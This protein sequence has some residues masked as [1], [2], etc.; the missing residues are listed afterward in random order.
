MDKYIIFL[1]SA[2]HVVH[3]PLAGE[4]VRLLTCFAHVTVV[5]SLISGVEKAL[6]IFGPR[7]ET[8][9]AP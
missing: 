3:D 5:R 7:H 8:M 6:A 4:L 2:D 9:L 1:V